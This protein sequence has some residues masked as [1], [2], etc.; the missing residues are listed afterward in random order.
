[1]VYIKSLNKRIWPFYLSPKENELFTSWVCR[2]SNAHGVKPIVFTKIYFDLK[3]SFWNRDIDIL[4]KKNLIEIS[5]NHSPLEKEQ[6]KNL[7]LS[8]YES[9]IFQQ[10]NQNG[11]NLNI[12][13]L[14][15]NHRTR[16]KFGLLYCPS[17][18][19]SDAFYKL[20]WRLT[21]SIVCTHCNDY[22]YDSCLNCD[23]NIIFFRNNIGKLNSLKKISSCYKC[24]IELSSFKKKKAPSAS[25]LNYQSSINNI[26][27]QGYY[28]NFQYSFHFFTVLNHMTRR[29]LT[30][31]KK[32][33]KFRSACEERYEI[34]LPYVNGMLNHSRLE[35][36]RVALMVAFNILD[37]WPDEFNALRLNAFNR[38]EIDAHLKEI[39][40]F[41]YE[42]LRFPCGLFPKNTKI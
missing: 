7:F 13:P 11:Y 34:K 36:R 9:I 25:E 15:I 17:C 18:L 24:G 37:N 26:I 41:L 23:S 19:C 5:E 32:N 38:S 21:S 20:E 33:N 31:S 1:M 22:L 2:L 40:Y 10:T 35:K 39:P 27:N 42:T 3:G 16:K 28:K 29:L 4:A 6:L 12:L 8:R 30:S 14:G